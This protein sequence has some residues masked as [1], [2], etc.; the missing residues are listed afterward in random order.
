MF[1]DAMLCEGVDREQALEFYA[2]V[3]L[4]GPDW[5]AAEDF[6]PLADAKVKPPRSIE[7]VEAALDLL[8][9]D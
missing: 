9:A 8:L 7:Q 6:A 5:T 4:F 1:Y 2:A 3:R